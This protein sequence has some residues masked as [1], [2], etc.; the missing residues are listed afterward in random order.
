MAEAFY[1]LGARTVDDLRSNPEV[2]NVSRAQQLGLQYY[3][4]LLQRIPR[5]EVTRLFEFGQSSAL[6][7]TTSRPF[8]ST[9]S[10]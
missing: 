9:S 1:D 8:P 10:S 3:D 7:F 4:D 5:D 6:T 2:Y